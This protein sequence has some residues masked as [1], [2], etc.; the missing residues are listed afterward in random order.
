MANGSEPFR[1]RNPIRD[2]RPGM[3]DFLEFESPEA[4]EQIA[5]DTGRLNEFL[6]GQGSGVRGFERLRDIRDTRDFI[7]EHAISE[8]QR[9]KETAE[10]VQEQVEET[11]E[12]RR[13][14]A[15]TFGR[16]RTILAG[17]RGGPIPEHFLSR[18]S[19]L[20]GNQ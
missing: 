6:V 20:S 15:R 18:P 8:R 2:R 12:A 17:G 9:R 4:A 16:T 13:R 14:A 19:I 3:P 11:R 7:I 1:I 10:R 5:R